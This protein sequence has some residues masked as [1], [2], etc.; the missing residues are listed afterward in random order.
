MTPTVIGGAS[1]N[2][3][4]FNNMRGLPK[5]HDSESRVRV[6]WAYETTTHSRI[7][8]AVRHGAAAR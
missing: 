8:I 5:K 6:S 1:R 2:M 4:S 3:L 7:R